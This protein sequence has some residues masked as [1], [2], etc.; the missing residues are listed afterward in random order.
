M[1][2]AEVKKDGDKTQTKNCNVLIQ[3]VYVILS[4]NVKMILNTLKPAIMDF[5][6]LWGST[7]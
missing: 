5:W 2:S 7:N 1:S 3:N 6:L 4:F